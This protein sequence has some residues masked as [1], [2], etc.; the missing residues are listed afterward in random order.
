MSQM[1]HKNPKNHEYCR[2]KVNLPPRYGNP[3]TMGQWYN[4]PE[5]KKKAYSACI[6]ESGKS[7]VENTWNKLRKCPSCQRKA[8]MVAFGVVML[9]VM[10]YK[11]K[12]SN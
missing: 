11:F 3:M 12:T 5:E 7:T 6:T 2:K 1:P 10:I 9:F 4:Q 8:F